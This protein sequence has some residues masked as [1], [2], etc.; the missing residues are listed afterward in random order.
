VA[1]HICAGHQTGITELQPDG[2]IRIGGAVIKL[3]VK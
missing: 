1:L 3:D 2:W